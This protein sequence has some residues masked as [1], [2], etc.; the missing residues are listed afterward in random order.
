MGHVYAKAAD[1]IY[2]T[3]FSN[4]NKLFFYDPHHSDKKWR[5]IAEF[6]TD[7][8]FFFTFVIRIRFLT[9][10]EVPRRIQERDLVQ[11]TPSFN[12]ISS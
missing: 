12:L 6:L 10:R 3:F 7:F 11:A 9:N 5:T 8:D 1:S 4:P 2:K